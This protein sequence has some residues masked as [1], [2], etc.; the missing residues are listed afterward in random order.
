MVPKIEEKTTDAEVERVRPKYIPD[1]MNQ[2]DPV[3]LRSIF[4]DCKRQIDENIGKMGYKKESVLEARMAAA[5]SR[6]SELGYSSEE[7]SGN[8]N[9][10]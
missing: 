6:L 4:N 2:T 8:D 10:R 7:D 5:L 1:I 3:I 9:S